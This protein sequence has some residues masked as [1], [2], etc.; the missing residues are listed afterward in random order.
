[1][2]LGNIMKRILILTTMATFAFTGCSNPFISSS[3]PTFKKQNYPKPTA[4]KSAIFQKTMMQVAL[5]TKGN[6][7]YNKMMLNTP[8]KKAWFKDLMF[9]FW[10][11]R[12]T[13]NQ[14]MQEGLAKYPAH[15]YEFAFVANGFQIRS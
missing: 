4:A 13:K 3:V 11:R 2:Y 5:S 15:R 9:R 6:A 1:M 12:I 10:D 14:F 8:E 7:K